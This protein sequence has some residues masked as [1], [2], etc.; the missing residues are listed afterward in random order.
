MKVKIL[1]A[2]FLFLGSY[3]P[4]SVI[5]LLQ[6]VSEATWKQ[7]ICWSLDNCTLPTLMN[8]DRSL[9][10]FIL[11]LISLAFFTWVLK[12]LPSDDELTVREAKTVPNDLI[13]YVF[14]YVVSFMGL[15]LGSN[16]KFY[17]FLVFLSWMF[18]ITYRSGQILMNPLLLAIGWQLHELE[19]ITSGK[20]RS[21]IALAKTRVY[22][23]NTL[24]SCV[25]QGIY[26]LTKKE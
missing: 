23:G 22:P 1:P 4:L 5:L 26:V 3:F 24:N 20:E 11:C 17:G 25:I 14:P 2:I 6:D 15:D 18:L 16:G 12:S 21:V 9:P 10:L 19:I 13:N 8:P 7:S